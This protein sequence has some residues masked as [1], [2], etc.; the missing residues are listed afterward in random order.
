MTEIK[1][2]KEDEEKYE[3][4]LEYL[5]CEKCKKFVVDE[6]KYCPKC[7]ITTCLKC[8]C[9]L[10]GHE[11]MHP[12]H[13]ISLLEKLV[14]KCGK[15][16]KTA[17]KYFDLIQHREK[18]E[19]EGIC[20][21]CGQKLTK[22]EIK[23]H[24]KNCSKK[25]KKIDCDEQIE[26]FVKYANDMNNKVTEYIN[27]EN[28]LFTENILSQIH[29][30]LYTPIQENKEEINNQL[31]IDS[32]NQIDKQIAALNEEKNK[33][34]ESISSQIQKIHSAAKVPL[35]QQN[36][37]IDS[38]IAENALILD[39]I[40]SSVS[41]IPNRCCICGEGSACK[42]F[43]CHKCACVFCQ[44]KCT[45]KCGSESCRNCICPSDAVH[46]D[47]CESSS[48]C[49]NCMIKCFSDKCHNI[50]CPKC[51]SKNKHQMRDRSESCNL[52]KCELCNDDMCIMS[53]I[54]C[55]HCDKRICKKCF[56]KDE[57]HR[58]WF[59]INKKIFGNK[60]L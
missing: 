9:Q 34:Y 16:N 19:G 4:Y 24:F 27:E 6:F 31:F 14:F 2:C 40:K 41:L 3:E 20:Q 55:N 56:S 21:E 38:I 36:E 47:L 33:I 29:K 54:L 51:F 10:Q 42:L 44:E 26:N 8:K 7:N 58:A 1:L 32:S 28:L 39:Y 13:I 46:C 35:Q 48:Y 57:I 37:E 43:F 53:S 45:L 12:R 15:C 52:V 30:L 49:E 5:K 59:K 18:C 23:S 25:I 17:F 22:K 60:L 11:S 50:F